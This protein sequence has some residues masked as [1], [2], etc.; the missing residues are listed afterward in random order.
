MDTHIKISEQKR[1]KTKN[2]VESWSEEE[3]NSTCVGF[4]CVQA[5]N[6]EQ[7]KGRLHREPC[8][9]PPSSL[10]PGSAHNS[11]KGRVLKIAGNSENSLLGE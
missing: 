6:Q 9:V 1:K 4:K 7:R 8:F 10:Q 11:Q 2:K 5:V 3:E